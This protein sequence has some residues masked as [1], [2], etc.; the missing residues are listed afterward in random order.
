[1]DAHHQWMH[2][3]QPDGAGTIFVDGSIGSDHNPGTS[4]APV[5][6]V[7][8]GVQLAETQ[9]KRVAVCATTTPYVE[10]VVANADRM[11]GISGGFRCGD[12]SSTDALPVISA[13]D[14]SR[15]A[16]SILGALSFTLQRLALR[17]P[18]GDEPHPSSVALGLHGIGEVD[19]DGAL[20]S[21]GAGWTPAPH[22]PPISQLPLPVPAP[23]FDLTAGAICA[24][25]SGTT[26][27]GAPPHGPGGPRSGARGCCLPEH[28]TDRRGPRPTVMVRR[29]RIIC[30]VQ[31]P[32]RHA[33]GPDRAA[34][35]WFER[36]RR[37]IRG[38]RPG[39]WRWLS[40]RRVRRLRWCRRDKGPVRRL[41]CRDRGRRGAP[42][43]IELR[44]DRRG[45]R[46][47]SSRRRSRRDPPSTDSRGSRGA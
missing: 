26:A 47:R 31:M 19:I 29:A 11:S 10:F 23:R 43:R 12:W 15:P 25:P 32:R 17:A 4:G 39:R 18:D 40:G 9:G 41:E 44:P 13:P 46:R 33:S 3:R 36:N 27:G 37:R 22:A 16:L 38:R 6:T 20:I 45:R 2:V 8:Q 24:C 35:R 7:Q 1:M 5:R 30:R 34:D 14:A 28:T 21:A 42:S